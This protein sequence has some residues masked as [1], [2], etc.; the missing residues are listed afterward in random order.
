MQLPETLHRVWDD[1]GWRTAIITSVLIFIVESLLE[2]TGVYPGTSIGYMSI[3]VALLFIGRALTLR[4]LRGDL[5]SLENRSFLFGLV[6]LIL[7]QVVFRWTSLAATFAE[8]PLYWPFWLVRAALLLGGRAIVPYFD[9]P[10]DR[11]LIGVL[12]VNFWMQAG[13]WAGNVVPPKADFTWADHAHRRR[14]AR[15]LVCRPRL[16]G[17]R[18]LAAEPVADDLHLFPLVAGIRGVALR[19]L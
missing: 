1:T 12:F 11:W 16:Q 6:L 19:S 14:P 18:T 15:L 9:R 10:D 5:A 8:E 7:A 2:I 4:P 3:V 17:Q 13:M